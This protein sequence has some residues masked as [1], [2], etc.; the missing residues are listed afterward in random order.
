MDR[1]SLGEDFPLEAD[2]PLSTG[3]LDVNVDPAGPSQALVARLPTEGGEADHL[4]GALA[5]VRRDR[6]H[7]GALERLDRRRFAGLQA[8]A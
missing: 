3:L 1:A 8:K 6:A 2:R 5:A 7:L 4:E